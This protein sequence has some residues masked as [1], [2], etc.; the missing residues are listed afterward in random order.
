[1]TAGQNGGGNMLRIY[2]ALRT[3]QN[4]AIQ[5]IV[6]CGHNEKLM[7]NIQSEKNV[8]TA[9]VSHV[10]SLSD[11]MSVC[12]LLITKAGGLTTFEAIAR[13]L[14]M[15]LDM[16]TEPMPQEVGTTTMLIEAGLAKPLKHP[17]DIVPILESLENS[18]NRERQQLPSQHSLN[19]V[20]ASTDIAKILLELCTDQLS[21]ARQ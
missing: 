12:D 11:L 16:L 20:N 21:S 18:I 13:H 19:C 8:P 2:R 17:E 10:E 9:V 7:A 4:K 5:A 6:L 1:L 3:K 15:A 14:P